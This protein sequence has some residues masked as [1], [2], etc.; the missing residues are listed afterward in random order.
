MIQAKLPSSLL[1]KAITLRTKNMIDNYVYVCAENEMEQ[2]SFER[3]GLRCR[4][5]SRVDRPL[6]AYLSSCVSMMEFEF[7]SLRN[8]V[9]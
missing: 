8:S 7:P 6:D 2:S 4:V 3:D 5:M 9:M 1:M